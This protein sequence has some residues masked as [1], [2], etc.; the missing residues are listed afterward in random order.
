MPQPES[1]LVDCGGV[2]LHAR[3]WNRG[4]ERTVLV[5]HGVT[6]TGLDHGP[7]AERLASEGY[8]VV[9]P[10][11]VGC[12]LSD[13]ATDRE[14]GYG[15]GPLAEKACAFLDSLG[16]GPVDWIGTSKGGGLGIRVAGTMPGR[17]R[18]LILNDVGAT[19]PDQIAGALGER[20]GNP[21]RFPTLGAFRDHVARFLDRNG[22]SPGPARLD[23]IVT[24]WARRMEDG[25]VGYHYDPALSNQF[26]N[27]PE[28]FALWPSWDAIACPVL[29]LR[30][31]LSNVLS[32]AEAAEMIRRNPHA[33]LRLF[34]DHGHVNFLDDPGHQ[35]VVIDFIA[36]T[37][38][39]REDI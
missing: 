36:G 35:Q 19:L 15:L 38:P 12:G 33:R 25:T 24:G 28:D 7:L 34:A 13:W 4:G 1:L 5:W 27:N 23:E 2:T 31:G 18:S 39:D 20:L 32:D 21:P 30:G 6:G 3:I 29:I 10:D 14:Y 17:V 11:G 16:C 37:A 26:R 9:A 22:L 8:R